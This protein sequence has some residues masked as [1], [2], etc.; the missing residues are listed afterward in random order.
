VCDAVV[1]EDVDSN[2][3]VTRLARLHMSHA[4]SQVDDCSHVAS[5]A[6][7]AVIVHDVCMSMYCVSTSMHKQKSITWPR[8]APE[9]GK[10]KFEL[11]HT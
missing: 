6:T 5:Q 2:R 1:S 11:N 7:E 3:A 9:A 8:V 4:I 10:K